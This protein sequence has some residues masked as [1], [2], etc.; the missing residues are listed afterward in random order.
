MADDPSKKEPNGDGGNPPA[1]DATDWKALYEQQ[2]AE[3]EKW[4]AMSRKNEKAAKSNG[5][6]ASELEDISKRLADIESENA[7]LKAEAEHRELVAKVAKATGVSEAIVSTLAATD[8]EALTQAATAIA[9][10]YKTPGGAPSVPER[11]T[12]PRDPSSKTTAE[13]FADFIGDALGM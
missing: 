13:Q 9:E 3:A 12:F 4:K 2:K 10:A 11:G 1:D 7:R 8:E 5:D 6:A